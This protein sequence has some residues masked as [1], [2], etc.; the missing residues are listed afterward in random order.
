MKS[1]RISRVS[2]ASCLVRMLLCALV[3]FAGSLPLGAVTNVTLNGLTS[4]TAADTNVTSV[5]VIGHGFPSGTIPP[6]NV[7][8]TLNP[9]TSGGG[10]TGTTTAT[11]VT[12][13]SGTTEYVTF[14]VPTSVTV[15]AATSYQVSIS[16]TTSTGNAFQSVN[17]STLTVNAP[18]AITTSSPLPMGVVSDSYSQ[19]L[20]ATGGSGT[21]AWALTAGTLPGGLTLNTASG[22]IS[23]TPTASG[24]SHFEIKATDSLHMPASK[25]FALTINHALVI[26]TSS[27]LPAGAVGSNYSQALT[28]AGGS[29]TYT[30][31]VFAGSL[32]GGLTLN[33]AT[34]VISGQPTNTGTPKFEIRVTDGNQDTAAKLFSLTI[35]A[36]IVITTGSPLPTGTVGVNYSQGLAATGGS[37][38]Y[39][40]AVSVGSLPGGL[41][42]NAATG[43]I[44]GQPTMAIAS[45]FTI[46]ATDTNQATGSK[47]FAL[48]V[49]AAIVITTSSPLPQG[50]VGV[51]YS[52][53]VAATGGSGTY[54][55]SVSVG[56]LPAGLTLNATTG[57]ISGQPTTAI[58]ANFTIQATDT[59]QA[60]GSKQFALTINPA[61]VITTSSPLPKGTVGVIYSQ[62]VAATGGSGT[63]T[64]AVSV[65]S[66]PGGLT[67]NATTGLISGQPTAAGTPSFT[68]QVTDSNQA[69]AAKAFSV[70]IDAAPTITTPSPLPAG[71][72]GID[73]SETLTATGGS[74]Q[75]TWSVSAG[76]LPAGLSLNSGTGLIGGLPTTAATFN[77]TIQVTDSN[78]ATAS[79]AFVLTINPA[80][81]ITTVSPNWGNAGKTLQATITGANTNFVQATTTASFG[82]GVSVGGAADG[83]PGPVTVNSPTS[84]TA[85]LAISIT[86]TTGPQTVTVATG[87]QQASLV[88]G[89]TI[90]SAVPTLTV[91]HSFAGAP[92]D[93]ANLKRGVLIGSGGALYGATVFGGSLSNN[94]I[95][96]SLTPPSGGG[97]W[98]EAVLHD[99]AGFPTDGAEP[100][101][102]FVSD[103][104]GVL[105]STTSIGGSY[106]SAQKGLGTAFSLAPPSG[107]GSWTETLLHQF[108]GSPADGANPYAGMVMDNNGVFYGTTFNGGA[109]S[110][111]SVFSLTNS[112]GTWTETVLHSF[113]GSD[114]ANPHASVLIGAGGVLYGTTYYGGTSSDGTVFMLTPP[115]TPGGAWMET[116]LHNFTGSDGANPHAPVIID[117]NGVLYGTALMG[118]SSGDGTVFTLTPPGTPG[119]AWTF[120][121]LHT[122]TGPPGDGGSPRAGLVFGASGVLY[123]VCANGGS[124]SFG[125]V[126][127]LTP[128]ASQGGSWTET[129]LHNF[130]SSDGANPY[131]TLVI[132]GSGLLYG[133][134]YNGGSAN[135]GTVFTVTP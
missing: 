20:T 35:N 37:G 104:S 91:L 49:N 111:G 77:F 119:G 115:G 95:V 98:T 78:Q 44:S 113:S 82:P 47:Q 81:Q 66:L 24:T 94:G 116:V 38:T 8:V 133:T 45:N 57:L 93:G 60:R 129:I 67:L 21:Y 7:T 118:G 58:A 61:I 25:E 14:K 53:T 132:D 114:G 123:G 135:V 30:W 54:T 120:A 29:G 106:N 39:T 42:L 10:P 130:I 108:S 128:P 127:S 134:T 97:S 28:A 122:F 26:T 18:V 64:W 107:G 59:N 17:S 4:P 22:V 52:Q 105:Y 31:A 23:G 51:N 74:G 71:Q 99:F 76:S 112:G 62:T 32:P 15:S 34:G 9:T 36:A 89:F 117:S 12:V 19:T 109:S 3:L 68:I 103:N 2:G 110:D 126:Y 73:Y 56:S 11:A 16:G 5:T 131:A 43:L 33:A 27:P 87:M 6:A 125:T 88:N 102:D 69:T 50:T 63:Y 1:S 90:Y 96:Y 86:A 85:E 75:Y 70:T 83:Q 40:W 124:S 101:G 100:D 84:A 79:Q 80:A 121:L 72:V 41:T 55:W 13:E 65:G 48:T 46:Q 92:S